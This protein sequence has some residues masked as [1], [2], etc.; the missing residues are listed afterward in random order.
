V[1]SRLQNNLN[2]HNGERN[3]GYALSLSIGITHY[4]P[5]RPVTPEKLL[6][7]GDKLMYEQK[8]RKKKIL[9]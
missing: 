1:N 6:F 7:Q 2:L 5:E 3:S 4:D 9:R 8:I